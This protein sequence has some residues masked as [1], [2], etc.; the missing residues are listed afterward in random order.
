MQKYVAAAALAMLA[1]VAAGCGDT[2]SGAP[3]T[4]SL[5]VSHLDGVWSGPLTLTSV[6]GGE[7]TGAVAPSVFGPSDQGTLSMVQDGTSVTGRL[8]AQRTGLSCAFNGT[9]T[10]NTLSGDATSCNTTGLI[11]QCANGQA[12]ELRLVGSSVS[13]GTSGGT[14]TAS[15]GT[16]FNVFTVQSPQVGVGS[17][18]VNQAFTATRQ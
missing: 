16:T 4:P 13:G 2:V 11:V 8:T 18:V 1:A 17:L 15:V 7:C 10:I 3:T 9:A 6:S 5:A 12:R 14:I